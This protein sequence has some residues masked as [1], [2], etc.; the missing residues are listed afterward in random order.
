MNVFFRSIDRVTIL[1]L[2]NN[3]GTPGGHDLEILKVRMFERS[4]ISLEESY[5]V[6]RALRGFLTLRSLTLWKVI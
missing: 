5:L 1:D 3:V 2:L 6:K 4:E